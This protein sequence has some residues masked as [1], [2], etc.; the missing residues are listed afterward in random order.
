M[1]F[2]YLDNYQILSM[3]LEFNLTVEIQDCKDYIEQVL[4]PGHRGADLHSGWTYT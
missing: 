2:D 1:I 4:N 3:D